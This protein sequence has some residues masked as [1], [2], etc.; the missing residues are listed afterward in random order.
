M[1]RLP[2]IAAVVFDM[3]GLLI[4]SERAVRAAMIKVA[5]DFGA[6]LPDPVFLSMVGTTIEASRAIATA[7]FGGDFD[8]KSYEAA[9]DEEIERELAGREIL[10][11]G[12]LELLD[13]LEA[14]A[15]PSAVATSSGRDTVEKRLAGVIGRFDAIVARG[16]YARGKPHPDPYL[17]AARR[18]RV[19]PGRCLALEDSHHGVVAAHAAGMTTV[20]VPDLLPSTQ[21]IEALCWAVAA[22]LKDVRAMLA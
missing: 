22:S 5:V 7:H 11:E 6:E 17:E 12:V 14:R 18:L 3:D 19:D 13:H 2:A 4:D 1:R 8:L 10:K 20:M 21:E 16:D 9:V 15:I